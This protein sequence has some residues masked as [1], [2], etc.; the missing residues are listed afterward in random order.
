MLSPRAGRRRRV[1]PGDKKKPDQELAAVPA[2]SGAP[3][4]HSAACSA[5]AGQKNVSE[6]TGGNNVKSK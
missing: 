4:V 3:L 2:A 1:G 6:T 5:A